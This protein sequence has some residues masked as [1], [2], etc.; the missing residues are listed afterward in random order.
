MDTTLQII[1]NI[2]NPANPTGKL[3]HT[4][5]KMFICDEYIFSSKQ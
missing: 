5:N 4:A 1:L 2:P 3:F